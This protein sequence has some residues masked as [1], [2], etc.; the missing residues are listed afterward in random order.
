M[1]IHGSWYTIKHFFVIIYI[2][3]IIMKRDRMHST[4]LSSRKQKVA[5][6]QPLYSDKFSNLLSW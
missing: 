4:I 5:M 1:N 6:W 3:N 2:V